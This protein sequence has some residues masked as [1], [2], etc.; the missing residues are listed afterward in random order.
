MIEGKFRQTRVLGYLGCCGVQPESGFGK[1][2]LLY[3]IQY[4]C[5]PHIKIWYDYSSSS[6]H[7][8]PKDSNE[9][10]HNQRSTNTSSAVADS[11]GTDLGSIVSCCQF[12]VL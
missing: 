12:C 7:L 4:I 6:G 10:A 3:S 5:S 2:T 11:N 1:W 8:E 9:I